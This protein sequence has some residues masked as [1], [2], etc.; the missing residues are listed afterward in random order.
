MT[1]KVER[2]DALLRKSLLGE[3][4]I[5]TQFHLFTAHSVRSHKAIRPRALFANDVLLEGSEY[6]TKLL[7]HKQDADGVVDFSERNPYV[8]GLS[9]D[10]YDYASDSD[11]EDEDEEDLDR[12]AVSQPVKFEGKCYSKQTEWQTEKDGNC[13]AMAKDDTDDEVGAIA[14]FG[15]WTPRPVVV[16]TQLKV[17]NVCPPR[18]IHSRHLFVKDTAFRTWQA[19]LFYIYTDQILWSPLKSQ[20]ATDS[21]TIR[22]MAIEANPNGPP[23]CS[24]KSMYRLANKVGFKRLK[25]L[26]FSAISDSLSEH[27][28]IQEIGSSLT[29][30]YPEVLKMEIDVLYKH[31]ASKPVSNQLPSLARRVAGGGVPHGAELIVK[32]H[33]KLLMLHYPD[34]LTIEE[35]VATEPV[36]NPLVDVSPSPVKFSF[37]DVAEI[38]VP[39]AEAVSAFRFDS[40][41]SS[42]KKNKKKN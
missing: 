35:E 1:T 36:T 32:L 12:S 24:P 27:N 18:Y 5:N 39:K 21:K 28:I 41:L 10:D 34:A 8:E 4:L 20:A 3:E 2:V 25:K 16:P 38:E 31:I 6:F 7:V 14:G 37:P 42:G 29:S 11:L 19:L 26:A 40:V 23:P 30:K 22:D 17:K 33:Q 13:Q 9:L 15:T